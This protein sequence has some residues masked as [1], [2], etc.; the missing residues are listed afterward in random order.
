MVVA[1]VTLGL[2]YGPA[3][4]AAVFSFL[5]HRHLRKQAARQEADDQAKG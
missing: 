5:S 1:A 4:I 3:A 2:K